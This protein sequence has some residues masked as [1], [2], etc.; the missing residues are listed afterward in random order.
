[1]SDKL[2][3]AKE[4]VRKTKDS[5]NGNGSSQTEKFPATFKNLN[6]QKITDLLNRYKLSIEA[7]I[8]KHLSADRLISIAASVIAKN[9]ALAE[10][11]SGSLIG[12]VIQ[13]SMLGFPPIESLG[14]CYFVPFNNNKG[15]RERPVWVKEVQFIIGYKGYIELS[16]RSGTVKS[17]FSYPVF[18][19]DSFDYQLGTDPWIKHKPTTDQDR[20]RMTHVYAVAEYLNGGMNFVVLTRAEVDKLRL[21][22]RSQKRGISGAWKTDFERM[23]CAKAC[24]QLSTYLP[25]NPEI[26]S[27]IAT[28]EAVIG[29]SSLS[30]DG[31][32]IDLTA[33]EGPSFE[34]AE[35]DL[36]ENLD[37]SD[38]ESDKEKF[39]D[40]K[41]ETADDDA[42]S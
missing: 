2:R 18:E 24:R 12:A 33:V 4:A 15:T 35:L 42:T 7:A 27:A 13:A 39:L 34:D 26:Q 31:T 40:K 22:N 6:S 25:L 1:M 10:C 36:D 9:P 38:V 19:N 28:D 17:L 5:A 23:S 21:R 8:P 41:P 29:E 16:R 37:F 14:Y 20:G 30:K 32:G 11:T 3:K